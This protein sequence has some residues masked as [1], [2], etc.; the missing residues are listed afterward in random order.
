MFMRNDKGHKETSFILFRFNQLY[1]HSDVLK[2]SMKK[3]KTKNETKETKHIILE[4]HSGTVLEL[5]CFYPVVS[6]I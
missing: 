4:K 2:Y 6:G 3:Y 1:Q 5:D